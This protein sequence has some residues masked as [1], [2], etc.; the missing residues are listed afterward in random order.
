MRSEPN[1]VAEEGEPSERRPGGTPRVHGRGC[2]TCNG[3]GVFVGAVALEYG[4]NV[5][6]L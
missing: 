6:L 2:A 4:L 1:T 3:S 5:N